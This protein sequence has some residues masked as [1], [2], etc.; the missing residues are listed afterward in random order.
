M[1]TNP[2]VGTPAQ[3]SGR[4]EKGEGNN[5]RFERVITVGMEEK[6]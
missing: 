2:F 5:G 3:A 1:V 4:L 6:Y